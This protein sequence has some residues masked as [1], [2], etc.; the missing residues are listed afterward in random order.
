MLRDKLIFF[1]FRDPVEIE[2]SN[3]DWSLDMDEVEFNHKLLGYTEESP[4]KEQQLFMD[5][6]NQER[7]DII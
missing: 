6:L 4:L 5:I 1:Q 3:F 2:P 7:D